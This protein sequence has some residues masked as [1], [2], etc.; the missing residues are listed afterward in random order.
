MNDW[1]EIDA[2]EEVCRMVGHEPGPIVDVF[3]TG[4]APYCSRCGLRAAL[5]GVAR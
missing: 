2:L 1:D 5:W 3:G 4:E